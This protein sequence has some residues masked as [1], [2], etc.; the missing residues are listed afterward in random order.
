MDNKDFLKT[1][2]SKGVNA[3]KSLP[4]GYDYS[5]SD[6][7]LTLKL[8]KE[9]V[10]DN[11][12]ND[13][14]AFESWALV[15]KH[16]CSEFINSVIIDWEEPD[17]KSQHF[18]RFVY[19]LTRFIQNYDWVSSKQ[20]PI[21]PSLLVCSA[22][23]DNTQEKDHYPVGSEDWLECNFVEQKRKFYDVIDH[24]LPV[25]LFDRIAAR[26]NEYSPA[27]NSQIDIWAI[28]DNEFSIFELKIPKNKPL[29]IISELMFYT[30]VVCDLLYHN[31]LIDKDKA[32]NA[33]QN[34]FRGFDKFY[35]VYSGNKNISTLRA[36]FLAKEFHSLFNEDV[37]ELIN[38][39]IRLK[40]YNIR[41]EK[42][43]PFMDE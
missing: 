36:V 24:Q 33:V 16:Y 7:T 41:F 12:Q 28:K 1:I 38:Q 34:K 2:K 25:G 20:L 14:S 43:N 23:Y 21:M 13:S 40:R 39:S 27:G 30:N 18:N 22:P 19:R 29:G 42:E 15:L 37:L 32:E 9:G 31:I 3:I 4:S 10:C 17:K 6:K 11:M 26:G 35:E 8:K 5:I